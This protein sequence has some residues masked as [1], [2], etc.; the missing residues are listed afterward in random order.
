MEAATSLTEGN[1][2]NLL[3]YSWIDRTWNENRD[4]L[5]PIPRQEITLSNGVVTQNPGWNE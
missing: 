2:G 5:Y 3:C 4:Y 1:Y